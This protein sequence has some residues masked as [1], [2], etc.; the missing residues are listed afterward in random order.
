[1]FPNQR[2]RAPITEI[3]RVAC[4]ITEIVTGPLLSPQH[5]Q[6]M[7]QVKAVPTYI[8]PWAQFMA[9]LPYLPVHRG[10]VRHR[11][12]PSD[13]WCRVG[14]VCVVSHLDAPA[15]TACWAIRAE[16]QGTPVGRA[17]TGS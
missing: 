1:M 6:G 7:E 2:R 16:G 15:M 3:S 10:C 12:G 14:A 5:K 8:E 9:N 13:V 11:H 17:G 4:G